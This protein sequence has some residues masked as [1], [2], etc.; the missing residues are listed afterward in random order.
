LE[1]RG[2]L[3][4]KVE[5]LP[6]DAELSERYAAGKP[7]TRPEVGVLLSYSKIVLFDAIVASDLPDDPYFAQ[8]LTAYFPK[9][10]QKAYAS[11]IAHHR[12]HREIIATVL[13]NEVINRGGPG[14]TQMLSDITGRGQVDVVKAA[15]IAR[16]AYELPTLWAALDALD[17]QLDGEVQNDLYEQIGEIFAG[18]T[19]FIL[20]TGMTAGPVSDAVSRIRNGIRSLR[21]AIAKTSVKAANLPERVPEALA[22]EL[23]VLPN[24]VLVPEIMLISERSGAP[25]A[26]ATEVYFHATE[27]FRVNRFLEAGER[28]STADHYENLAIIRSLQQIASAR[29]DIVTTALA[30]HGKDKKPLETWLASDRIRLNRISSE[31]LAL[32]EGG[33][34]TLAKMMV[35]ASLFTDLAQSSVR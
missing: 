11:D 2:E 1:V 9:Q 21:G 14:F 33:E 28:F 8:V 27:T 32:S 17:G 18:A 31:L 24:L 30:S 20:Q 5:T 13:A 16:D 10:M 34:T 22:G 35:A 26:R 4:R 7:L 19:I 23:D 6:D 15:Y 12:L 3:N 25:L 29:R